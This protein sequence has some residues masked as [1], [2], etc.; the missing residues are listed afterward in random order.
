MSRD[1]NRHHES[2]IKA[3]WRRR[4][5]AREEHGL[6]DASW[7]WKMVNGKRRWVKVL[8]PDAKAKREAYIEKQARYRAHHNKCPC[9]LCKRPRYNRR[10]ATPGSHE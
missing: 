2:R 1:E 9:P 6:W 5:R 8:V 3:N 7:R 10:K 4:I